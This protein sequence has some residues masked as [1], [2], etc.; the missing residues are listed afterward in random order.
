MR[1]SVLLPALMISLLLTGCGSAGAEERIEKQRDEFACAEQL[2]FTAEVTA[3]LPE[4]VFDCTLRCTASP[5]EVTVEVL[6]PETIAGIKAHIRD[7]ETALSYDDVRLSIGGIGTTGLHPL[8]AMPLLVQALQTGHVIRT[9]TEQGETGELIA[10]DIFVDE[11]YELTLWFGGQTLT[12]AAA[13][14]RKDGAV[15]ISCKFLEFQF[16]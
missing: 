14:F 2:C 1:R 5:E 13:E 12:P 16:E 9:W 11:T 6:E 15:C 10:A 8:S 7:G 4:T 3:N